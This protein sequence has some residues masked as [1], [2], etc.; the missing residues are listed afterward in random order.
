MGPNR[1]GFIKF[2]FVLPPTPLPRIETVS[3]IVIVIE[4]EIVT[5]IEIENEIKTETDTR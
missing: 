3:G 4:I 2:F 5:E 1:L